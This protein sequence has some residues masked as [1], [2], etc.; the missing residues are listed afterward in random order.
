MYEVDARAKVIGQVAGILH[1]SPE[2]TGDLY[3]LWDGDPVQA[4]RLTVAAPG[5]F[6]VDYVRRDDLFRMRRAVGSP[7]DL[8]RAEELER[9]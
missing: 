4:Q 5:G 1:G 8:R 7:K 9:L 2:L 3:L 6:D